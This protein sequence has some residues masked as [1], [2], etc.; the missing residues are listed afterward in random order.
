MEPTT[1]S[2][3]R[4]VYFNAGQR[5]GKAGQPHNNLSPF[6]GA[7][8]NEPVAFNDP[9][10]KLRIPQFLSTYNQTS[11]GCLFYAYIMPIRRK[12][13]ND[14]FLLKKLVDSIDGRYQVAVPR[15]Q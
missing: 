2:D 5:Y 8:Q 1:I 6:R 13:D 3:M 15:N 10:W 7:D 14:T 12:S 4:V 11:I 9:F